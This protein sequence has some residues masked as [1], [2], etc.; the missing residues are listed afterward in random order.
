M[1][2]EINNICDVMDTLDDVANE[3]IALSITLSAALADES[4]QLAGGISS[5]LENIEQRLQGCNVGIKKYIKS[6]QSRN[7]C[8]TIRPKA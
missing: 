5:L 7:L 4:P 1:I 6:E 8:G 2:I 3:T